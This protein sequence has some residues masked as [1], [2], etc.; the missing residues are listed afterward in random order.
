MP[1]LTQDIVIG[2]REV[3]EPYLKANNL[4]V[5]SVRGTIMGTRGKVVITLEDVD[6]GGKV[7]LPFKALRAGLKQEDVGKEVVIQGKK[8]KLLGYNARNRVYPVL[9]EIEGKRYKISL[10]HWLDGAQNQ[11][12]NGELGK[13]DDPYEKG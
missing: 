2:I 10:R 11:A 5:F 13:L 3:V 4:S 9:I 12:I 1:N 6:T 8:C 7:V